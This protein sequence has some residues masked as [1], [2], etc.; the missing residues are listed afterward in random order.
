MYDASLI[1]AVKVWIPLH[2]KVGCM[3]LLEA[4]EL[5]GSCR[6]FFFSFFSPSQSKKKNNRAKV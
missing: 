2:V 1:T 4:T 6:F 5:E 3:G